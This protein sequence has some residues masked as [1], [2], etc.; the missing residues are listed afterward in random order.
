MRRSILALLI[1][2]CPLTA[3]AWRPDFSLNKDLYSIGVLGGVVGFGTEHQGIGFGANVTI[4]GVSADFV[5]YGPEHISTEEE[6]QWNDRETFTV[7]LGY[8]IPIFKFL[9]VYPI[10]GYSE[11][12]TGVTDGSK[13]SY[14]YDTDTMMETRFNKYTRDWTEHSFNYGGGIAIKPTRWLTI[15][16]VASRYAIYGGIGLDLSK[17]W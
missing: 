16:M 15:H 8:H 5:C 2:L 17:L 14:D 9:S 13:Y 10:V 1:V 4:W 7:N 11:R 6:R 3:K 12:S